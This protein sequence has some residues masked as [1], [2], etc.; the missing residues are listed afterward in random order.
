MRYRGIEAVV[1]QGTATGRRYGFS[2][3]SPVQMVD[4]RD[5]AALLRSGLFR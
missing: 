5:A 3:G 2:S 1:V 4:A